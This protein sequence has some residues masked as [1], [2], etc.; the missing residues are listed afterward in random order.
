MKTFIDWVFRIVPALVLLQTLFYKFSAAPESVYIFTTLGLE[1]Y[2]RIGIGIAELIMGVLILVPRTTW[3]GSLGAIGLM[4]GAILSHLSVLGIEIND[5]GGTLFALAIV[6]FIISLINLIR[7][8]QY[9]M[10]F[11]KALV[12]K[13]V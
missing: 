10:S 11:V 8:K 2:G 4:G 3:I 1:P 13:K 12:G 9:L 5:D 7:E 6:V